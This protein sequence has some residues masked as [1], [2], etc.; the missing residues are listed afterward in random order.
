MQ[1]EYDH[2]RTRFLVLQRD[3]EPPGEGYSGSDSRIPALKVYF[4]NLMWQPGETPQFSA[5]DHVQAI[6]DHAGQTMIDVAVVNTR[7]IPALLQERYAAKR[8]MP[9]ENDIDRLRDMGLNV[10]AAD[11]AAEGLKVRHDPTATAEIPVQL[12]VDGHLWRALNMKTA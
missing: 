11:L 2:S 1:S 4:V 12:A 8:A 6:R 3:S 10:L 7:P 9:V 5:A